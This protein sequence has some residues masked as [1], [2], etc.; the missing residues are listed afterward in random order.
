MGTIIT[1]IDHFSGPSE[2]RTLRIAEESEWILAA[3]KDLSAFEPLYTRYYK[4]IYEYIYRRC[5]D[6]DACL[7]ITAITFE[8]AMLNIGKFKLQGF[9]FGSWLFR[10]AASE[11]GNYYRKEN[12]ERKIYVKTEGIRDIAQEFESKLADEE[13][14]QTLL[15]AME[16][17]KPDDLEL[18][19]MR[20]F[21]K[22][23]FT[24][25]AGFIDTNESNARVRLHRILGRLKDAF[26][27]ESKL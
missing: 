1:H 17:M 25:I 19:V 13:N 7:D 26:K 20:Y 6:K 16:K 8:K 14:I 12:K 3:K 22:R 4:P 21:E 27:E 5:D 23:S 11:I 2:S 9:P 18:I 24:D 10:I 15:R